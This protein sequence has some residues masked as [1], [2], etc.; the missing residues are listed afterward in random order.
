[1]ASLIR[2]ALLVVMLVALA[3]LGVKA[4]NKNKVPPPPIPW[5]SDNKIQYQEV[6]AMEG[7][8]KDELY[9][10]AKAWVAE[11]YRSGQMATHLDDAFNGRL[12]VNGLDVTP[13]YGP[14]LL[15]TIRKIW[16]TLTIEAKDGRYRYTVDDFKVITDNKGDTLALEQY[17]FF[18]PSHT[19]QYGSSFTGFHDAFSAM[20]QSFL[21]SLKAGMNK[22]STTKDKAW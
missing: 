12:V 17:A 14:I 1:M 3:A 21:E 4:K 10:R 16:H 19:P 22:P 11:T 9:A 5:S 18:Y 6:V 20:V 13:P 15:R 7:V 2:K 8:S